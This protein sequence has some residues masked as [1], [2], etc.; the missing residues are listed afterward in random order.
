VSK[1]D[2]LAWVAARLTAN[3]EMLSK[4]PDPPAAIEPKETA[5]KIADI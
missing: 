1:D 2:A 3:W 4:I 5:N